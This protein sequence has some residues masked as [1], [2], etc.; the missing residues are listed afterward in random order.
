MTLSVMAEH[1]LG[2]FSLDARF[3][4]DGPLTAIFGRSGAGKTSLVNVIAGLLDPERGRV[5]VN[6]ETLLDTDAGIRVPVHRRR[7]G[8][9]FQESRLFPHLSVRRNLLYGWWLAP[10]H[11]RSVSLDE[12]VALL[13]LGQLMGRRTGKLSGGEQR[14]VSIGRALLASPRLLLMDEPLASLDEQ[15]KQEIIPFLER[16]RDQSRVPIV[17]VS[18]SIAE[19][20]RLATTVVLM[21]EGKV[22]VAGPTAEIMSRVDLFPLT[23]R[24]EAGAML[25]ATVEAHDA[26]SG[27]THLR[28]DAGLLRIPLRALP[29]GA[30]LR[31]HV[32]ARDVILAVKPPE[33]LSA[34]NCLPGTIAEIGQAV[35]PI[36]DVAIDCAG[37]RILARVTRYSIANLG[38]E[39]GGAVFAVIKSITF[40]R[41]SVGASG[42]SGADEEI[43]G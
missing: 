38:L 42:T 17:Y 41:R 30:S 28:A 34:L 33:G 12:V 37:T 4:S 32:R 19:V 20:A 15:R 8:Y 2:A 39:R 29:L 22:A 11:D 16:L 35:G 31:V 7:I 1:R 9:V 27:L 5:A 25:T 36:V 23:G 40:D 3:E 10:R 24:A 13:G 26:A 18:H 6:G 21:S 14:R 43:L